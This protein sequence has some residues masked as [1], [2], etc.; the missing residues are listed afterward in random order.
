MD[1]LERAEAESMNYM[2]WSTHR[3]YMLVPAQAYVAQWVSSFKEFPPRQK[4][5]S[6]SVDQ[7]MAK[8]SE[9]S[10]GSQ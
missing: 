4:P 10:G 8:L 6:F 5:A 1:Q 7:V 2:N 9:A 3:M